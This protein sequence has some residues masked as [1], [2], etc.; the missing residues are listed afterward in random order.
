MGFPKLIVLVLVL[1]AIWI[2]YRWVMAQSHRVPRRREPS[3]P[4]AITAEDLV[5][6][7]V[8]AAY[9]APRTRGCGRA[10]CPR[11]R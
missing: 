8:C 7:S 5:P 9:V 4:R 10:D 1:A 2:G 3:Q 6:C 11:P